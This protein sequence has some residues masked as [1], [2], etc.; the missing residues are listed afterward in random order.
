MTYTLSQLLSFEEFLAQ[1][2][3]NP[4]YELADG[5]L[6]DME[7]TGP[8]ETVAGKLASKLSVELERQGHPWFI[9]RTCIIRPFTEPATARRPDV[10]VLDETALVNEPLWEREPVITLGAS[11]KLIIEVVSTNWETDYARK[12]EEY[13]LLGI[14]EYWIVDYRGLGGVAFIGRPKQPT[15]TVC[16]LL[17]EDYV[18]QPYRLGQSIVSPMLP[19]LVLKLDDVLP[20]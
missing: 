10:V 8:H 4:R 13:A 3:N 12:V 14:A 11:I 9:P 1:Y 7:P 18:Q 6:I 17:D 19:S 20:R 15:F 2:G 16:Q 5:E